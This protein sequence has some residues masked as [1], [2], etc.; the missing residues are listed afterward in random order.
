[1]N[2]RDIENLNFLRLLSDEALA[3][4][5]AQADDEDQ[6]YALELLDAWEQELDAELVELYGSI[7]APTSTAIH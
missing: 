6:E 2:Q 4:W 7:P 1:M 5:F 3:I